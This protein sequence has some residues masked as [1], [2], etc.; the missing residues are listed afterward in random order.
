MVTKRPTRKPLAAKRARKA[1]PLKP[2]LTL[3]ERIAAIGARIPED[4]LKD[5]P[6]DAARNLDH[7]LYGSPKQ[8]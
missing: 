3:A 8:D 4:Q 6:T 5:I 2:Q 1:T 7:Y